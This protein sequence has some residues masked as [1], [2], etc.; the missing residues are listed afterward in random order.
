[1]EIMRISEPTAYAVMRSKGFPRVKLGRKVYVPRDAFFEWFN[2][3]AREAANG[4]DL[5]KRETPPGRG[6]RLQLLQG[7]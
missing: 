2:N 4:D 1:M 6:K 7:R 5:V 3:K